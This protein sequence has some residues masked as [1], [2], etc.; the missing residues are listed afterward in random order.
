M[1]VRLDDGDQVISSLKTLMGEETVPR[2][3]IAVSAVGM[4]RA[5]EIGYF[6]GDT[7]T[8]T[9]FED[10][11]EVLTMTGTALKDQYPPFHLHVTVNPQGGNAVGGHLFGGTVENTLELCFLTMKAPLKRVQKNVLRILDFPD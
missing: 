2:T 3:L 6:T 9:S 11:C 4:M 1:L 8:I 10:P 7:Y 5:I